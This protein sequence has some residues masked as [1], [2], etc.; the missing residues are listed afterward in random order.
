M[1][2][3][4]RCPRRSC[5]ASTPALSREIAEIAELSG[6]YGERSILERCR[7]PLS[8]Q[9]VGPKFAWLRRHEP[10]LWER[11]ERWFMASSFLVHR[12]TGEYV[13][14]HHSASQSDPLYDLEQGAFIADW[15]SEIAPG[16]SLPRLLWP[17]DVAGS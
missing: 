4:V 2:K 12:L 11:T 14:D 7:S 3:G 13:L 1:P 9:A 8:S 10:E 17:A 16:L 15:A 5:T 6:R